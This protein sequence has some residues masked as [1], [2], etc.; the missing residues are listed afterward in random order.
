MA[1]DKEDAS[2]VPGLSAANDNATARTRIDE[3]V[4]KIARLIGRQRTREEF[5]RLRATNDNR[6]RRQ[7]D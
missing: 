6:S 5:E 1:E 2:C 3:A 4:M 7:R